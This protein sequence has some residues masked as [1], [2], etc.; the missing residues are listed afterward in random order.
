MLFGA[1]PDKFKVYPLML[2][3]A[4]YTIGST[5]KGWA[6]GNL[7]AGGWEC[8]PVGKEYNSIHCESPPGTS[9]NDYAANFRAFLKDRET[10]KPFCFWYGSYEPH[11]GYR[12]GA[13]L[14]SGK[15]IEEVEVPAFLP[16]TPEVRNDLLD[17]LTEIE[18]HDRQLGRMIEMLENV[19]E[20][21][22]T[23]IVATSDNGMPFPRAK[24][25]LYDHGVHV[26]LAVRW[27]AQ[28]KAGRV[29]DDFV[30]LTDMAPTFLEIAGLEMPARMTGRSFKDVLL[31]EKSGRIDPTRDHAITARE[32][33]TVCRKGDVGYP[34][35]AIRTDDFLY[36]HNY[37]P[38]RWPAGDPELK[39]AHGYI[40]GDI[41]PN[42]T[43]RYLVEHKEDE[44]VADL[45]Q[46]AF[47]K[48]P[49][50][51]LYDVK[52][53]PDQV[54]NLADISDFARIKKEL[55]QQLDD[56]L[57]NT[58][59][60]RSEGK[61]PWDTYPYYLG[62]PDGIVPYGEYMKRREKEKQAL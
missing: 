58:E 17:Y 21:D 22:N 30:S 60:P 35:R 39:S 7:K 46:L 4:G 2:E 50:E 40:Y 49:P 13:G 34:A 32:R 47:G 31:S 12:R 41:D 37:E 61:S 8:N 23:I 15:K 43:K 44:N 62:N 10:G 36:I 3:Q 26:P 5:G 28:G 11:R 57:C 16:D 51:E 20:L 24:A 25:T 52:K 54:R 6:P 56:Y 14:K 38:S 55:R 9:N 59:D 48:R 19:G 29:V 18:W 1:L 42:P 27:G 33:H 45:F 53:D